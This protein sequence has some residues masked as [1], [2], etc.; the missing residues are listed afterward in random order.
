[1][2]TTMA[3]EGASAGALL[4]SLL[5]VAGTASAKCISLKDSSACQAWPEASVSTDSEIAGSL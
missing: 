5:A 1:M 3:R 4:L 2:T